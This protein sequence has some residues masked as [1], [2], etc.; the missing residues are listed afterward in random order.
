MGFPDLIRACAVLKQS[1]RRFRCAIYGDG[2]LRAQLEQA[3]H[4]VGNHHPGQHPSVRVQGGIVQAVGHGPGRVE[5][6]EHRVP[7]AD[8]EGQVV[9][10]VRT[11]R[12][13][14]TEG[15]MARRKIATQL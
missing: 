6:P 7:P 13:P 1:G 12:A 3:V 14:G 15:G 11:R 10:T 8:G 2:P 5:I 9:R 4:L